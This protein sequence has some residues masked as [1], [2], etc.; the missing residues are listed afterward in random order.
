MNS[1]ILLQWW[2]ADSGY[3]PLFQLLDFAAGPSCQSRSTQPSSNASTWSV[4][5]EEGQEAG[6]P[7]ANR[8][9]GPS[10]FCFG[11]F[12]YLFIA[13]WEAS[14]LLKWGNNYWE[15]NAH[16]APILSLDIISVSFII[17]FFQPWQ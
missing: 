6:D 4:T 11:L 14:W 3:T 1:V 8:E 7:A 13:T 5:V 17:I 12:I 2:H 15:E 10:M 16:P 9:S